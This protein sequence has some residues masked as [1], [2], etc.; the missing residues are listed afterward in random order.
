MLQEG[1]EYHVSARINRGEMVFIP[2]EDKELFLNVL[3]KAKKRYDFQVKNFCIMSNHLHLIIKPG[4]EES[5]SRIMQWILSVFAMA[6]NRRHHLKGHLWGERFFSKIIAGILDFL[7]TC[8]YIDDN[9]V[10]AGLVELPWQW[11]YGGLWHH[12]RGIVEIVDAPDPITVD[13]LPH[14]APDQ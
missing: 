12:R 11:E 1:A 2:Q 9:P 4:K 13:F 3:K 5:L 6:W 7:R 8:M 14:H 10:K